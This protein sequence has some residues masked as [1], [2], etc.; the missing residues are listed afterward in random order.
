MKSLV[1]LSLCALLTAC[2]GP[3][4]DGFDDHSK[5]RISAVADFEA[6]GI[7]ANGRTSG[8]FI[9]TGFGTSDEGIRY[10]DSNF[11]T[12]HD[13]W[14]W[15]RLLN[16]ARIPG[17]EG[18]VPVSGFTFDTI[19][20]IYA[21]AK[22]QPVLPLDLR[23]VDGDR[24][25][26]PR[27]YDLA[28]AV[29]PRAFGLGTLIH[30]VASGE[31]PERWAFQL[32]FTDAP[33]HADLIRYFQRLEA[34]LP[35]D[36]GPKVVWVVRSPQQELIAQDIE[37]QQLQY[38]DRIIRLK[39]LTA[40][41]EIEVYNDGI[42]AG[43]LRLVPSGTSFEGSTSSDILLLE[44]VPDFLPP[45]A[46]VVTAVPQTPL[47]HF[48]LLAKNRGIPNVYRAGVMEEQ[49]LLDLARF[50]SPVVI[51]A[52]APGEFIIKPISEAQYS[53]WLQSQRKDPVA[54]TQVDVSTLA[55]HV[56]LRTLSA[57]DSD[58][59]RPGLGGK[60]T[61][62][63]GLFAGAPTA[64]PDAVGALSIRSYVEHLAQF[65]P[66]L[67]AMLIA[68]GFNEDVRVRYLVLEGQAEFNKT[69]PS[70]VDQTWLQEFLGAHPAGDTLG[71]L[72]RE[73]GVKELIRNT[74]MNATTLAT[75]TAALRAQFGHYSHLQGL[76]FRSS[77][78]AED[79]E[80]F[81][82][83]GLYDSNTGFLDAALQPNA[84][85]QKK[86]IEWAIKKTWASYWTAE[87]YE[88]RALENIDHL[89][90]NMGVVV[91]ARFDD[92]KEK[93]NGVFL[94]TVQNG[95]V[96]MELNVQAGAVS[97]TN[98]TTTALPEIDRVTLAA[99]TTTPVITRVRGSTLVPA[100]TLLLSDAEL[101]ETFD[102]AKAVTSLWLERENT[103]KSVAQQSRTQVL[104]FEFRQVPE[105]WP[106][107]KMGTFPARVVLKQSRS[108]EPGI[109]GLSAEL[110]AMPFPKDILNRSR[111]VERRTCE[112]PSFTAVVLEALTSPLATPDVGYSTLPFT[113]QVQVTMKA[114][115]P[116]M[117]L[118][119]GQVITF[120]HLAL[121]S[122][123][124][125][126]LPQR[127]SL[128]TQVEAG[129]ELTGVQL[130]EGRFQLDKGSLTHLGTTLSCTVEVLR[131]TPTEFLLSLL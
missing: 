79:V 30:V 20:S 110:A 18:I 92:D 120:D 39:D 83:A 17:R 91:H 130:R 61:G 88:E 9:I 84:D 112:S 29:T 117:M 94:C 56:D 31:R 128:I 22:E 26:S 6:F 34:T 12:L 109:R 4:T 5:E 125:P 62:Y 115:V 127:W 122:P 58:S 33:T 46:G 42:T 118:S 50:R 124:H 96:V 27:F 57:D 107:L 44:D 106:A 131:S 89:S 75:I 35:A 70:P 71:D 10:T 102:R 2:P 78:T 93:S 54:V 25:Y 111:R 14:Y 113:A 66:R 114:D 97:V 19:A 100:G 24:L 3:G 63:L 43:R 38:W 99:G 48:N 81:N 49:E 105:G 40:A 13:E 53:V 52:T 21:W 15:F 68:P 104:D 82:G 41:G 101:L 37:R 74:P 16:G 95:S 80:G 126:E 28:L 47:A 36:V 119:A 69:H 123:S 64:T 77:S 45:A 23:W 7:T 85:D 8:K 87:A 73:G 86:T 76:R 72:V 51:K 32:E 103:G 1:P 11:Y 59:L 90:G 116:G 129:R 67:E 98:P 121:R 108:L 60:A 65:R 55:Y